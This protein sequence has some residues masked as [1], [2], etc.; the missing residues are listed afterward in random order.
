MPTRSEAI[1]LLRATVDA[2]W[3]GHQINVVKF[4]TEAVIARSLTTPNSPTYTKPEQLW[5]LPD[6]AI[7]A[8]TSTPGAPTPG[9][10]R[11]YAY[12]AVGRPPI[13]LASIELQAAGSYSVSGKPGQYTYDAPTHSI[14]WLSGGA[15]TNDFQGAVESNALIRLRRNT[16]C[17]H[18]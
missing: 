14:T 10:F 15:K 1:A 8:T 12:G 2:R 6:A 16:I 7:S 11:C 5:T 3:V 9:K 4:S 13:F 18:E 17:T